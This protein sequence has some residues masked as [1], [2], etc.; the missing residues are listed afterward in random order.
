[1]QVNAKSKLIVPSILTKNNIL[2][3]R[4][5]HPWLGHWYWSGTCCMLAYY[6]ASCSHA[7]HVRSCDMS[8]TNMVLWPGTCPARPSLRYTTVLIMH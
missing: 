3:P 7:L 1:M 6:I 8:G 2:T 5:S 4:P